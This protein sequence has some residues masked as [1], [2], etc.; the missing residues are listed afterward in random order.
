M[1]SLILVAPRTA[2]EQAP[3]VRLALLRSLGATFEMMLNDVIRD[4]AIVCAPDV[5][6]T[7]I[8]DETGCRLCEG[9]SEALQEAVRQARSERLLIM[10]AGCA[11]DESLAQEGQRL[12]DQHRGYL[13]LEA[14]NFLQ[15]CAPALRPIGGL[16]APRAALAQVGAPDLK[17]IAKK[18]GASP[19]KSCARRLFEI[20]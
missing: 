11:P 5:G 9:A 20:V 17:K 10:E 14:Q 2:Q 16:I 12:S 4:A 18:I 1:F 13:R 7:Q 15:S 8:A 19:L 6:A 3:L